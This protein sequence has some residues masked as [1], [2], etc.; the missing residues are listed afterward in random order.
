MSGQGL[1]ELHRRVSKEALEKR[2][3]DHHQDMERCYG[4]GPPKDGCPDPFCR[5]MRPAKLD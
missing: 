1:L 5:R 2:V 3:E 4:K